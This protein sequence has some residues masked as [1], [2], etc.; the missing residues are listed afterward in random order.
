MRAIGVCSGCGVNKAPRTG[1]CATCKRQRRYRKLAAGQWWFCPWCR[2]PLPDEYGPKTQLDH[3]YPKS[4]GGSN[5]LDNLR[6]MHTRCNSRKS[7]KLTRA[8][9]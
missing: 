8:R 9:R 2:C 5:K 3:W 1:V 4:R 6:A 7:N